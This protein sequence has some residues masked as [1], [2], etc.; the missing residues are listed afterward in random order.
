MCKMAKVLPANQYGITPLQMT[1][2]KH[3]F[4]YGNW[5][6]YDTNDNTENVYWHFEIR[7]FN[8]SITTNY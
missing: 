2:N 1:L 3:G 5:Y 4:I 8:P 7:I 6:K